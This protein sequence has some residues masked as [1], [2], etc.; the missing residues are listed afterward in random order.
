MKKPY[1]LKDIDMRKLAETMAL[2]CK[3]PKN[4]ISEKVNWKL[5]PFCFSKVSKLEFPNSGFQIW[6]QNW[7]WKT[8]KLKNWTS[9]TDPMLQ[10]SKKYSLKIN[11]PQMLC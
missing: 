6:G 1:V 2:Y 8:G 9:G 11:T 7:C 4:K 3:N 5:K 10:R